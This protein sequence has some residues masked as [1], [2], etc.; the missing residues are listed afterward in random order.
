MVPIF[1]K[2]NIIQT[3]ELKMI[4]FKNIGYLGRLGNQMFQFAST[5]GTAKKMGFES[6]FPLENCL[7]NR[8]SGPI[9]TNG[10]PSDVK[11]DLLECFDIEQKYFKNIK[12][13][14]TTS[15]FYENDFKFNPDILNIQPNTD[16]YGYFQ[17]ELYFIDVREEILKI[18]KFKSKYEESALKFISSIP[19]SF[20]KVSIHVRRGDYLLYPNH[21]PICSIDYYEK[22]ISLFGK[23]EV[24]FLV[25]SDDINWCEKNFIG[26]NFIF[27]NTGSHYTDLKIMSLCDHHIIANSSYSWWGAWLNKKED[28]IVIAPSCWFGP[29]IRKDTSQIYCGG[30]I[31]I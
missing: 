15:S 25:F 29:E 5:V 26:E 24:K 22:S 28:K 23:E 17:D 27:V 6:F 14:H 11:C 30:W 4:T 2:Q 7:I 12:D 10:M 20:S 1:R 18:F 19:E 8:K 31:K 16:L 3:L 9:D 13:L 21:H